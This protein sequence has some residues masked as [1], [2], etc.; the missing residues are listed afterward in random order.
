MLTWSHNFS[1]LV[2]LRQETP[3]NLSSSTIVIM[4]KSSAIN[5]TQ[6]PATTSQTQTTTTDSITIVANGSGVVTADVK[7]NRPATL[8]SQKDS[9]VDRV[10]K[11][12]ILL[13]Q[14]VQTLGLGGVQSCDPPHF[15]AVPS[16]NCLSCGATHLRPQARPDEMHVGQVLRS[17]FGHLHD[18]VS[19]D[20][21]HGVDSRHREESITGGDHRPV[22]CY[23]VVVAF[24]V[25]RRHHLV[26]PDLI[27]EAGDSVD[28]DFDGLGRVDQVQV[29]GV[30]LEG[31]V[32]WGR[33][34]EVEFDGGD[35]DDVVVGGGVVVADFDFVFE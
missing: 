2:A 26:Y 8:L 25:V 28:D 9:R 20:L 29:G 19:D 24:G 18:E 30:E 23:D 32:V 34:V 13:I 14:D 22:D 5:S 15:A 16:C 31:V 10:D 1:T 6:E 11:L 27:L 3:V 35:A 21:S 33:Q 17:L 12:R 4:Y 7:I